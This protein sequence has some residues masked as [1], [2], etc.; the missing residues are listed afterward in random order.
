MIYHLYEHSF[1]TYCICFFIR[2]FPSFIDLLLH[3]QELDIDVQHRKKPGTMLLLHSLTLLLLFGYDVFAA[4][5][6][7][8]IQRQRRSFKVG[9]VRRDGYIPHGSTALRRAYHKYGIVPRDSGWDSLDFEPA[10]QIRSADASGSVSATSTGSEFVCPVKVGGQTLVLDFDTGSADMWIMNSQLPPEA[11]VGHMVFDTSR[12]P[13]FKLMEGA[14]FNISY[15]D[16]SFSYGPVGTDTVD[17]GGTVV[18]NQAFGL[19]TG[20]SDSFIHDTTSNGLVGLAFSSLSTVK[21]EKQ[22][23]FFENVAESLDEP[24]MT[25]LLKGGSGGEYE[26]GTIDTTK[27][28]GEMV[29]VSVD[30]SNGFWQFESAKFSIGDGNGDLQDIKTPTSIVDTGTSLMLVSPDVA[31]AYYAQVEGAV[32]SKG[33]GGFVYPC[34]SELPSLF[35]ALG[36]EG[37][38]RIPGSDMTFGQAGTNITTGQAL[39]FGG[40]QSN[41]GSNLQIYG[42]TFLRS[43]FVVFDMRGPSLRMA[44]PA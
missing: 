16:S 18:E 20:L 31:E 36:G 11:T 26:F 2:L 23:N 37:M 13:S 41:Q 28:Q 19:P 9:R 22:K 24:V 40:L 10:K 12:S 21:P 34:D 35:V 1:G 25:S 32:L 33:A 7:W 3:R 17:I 29:N 15:G 4:P 38:A 39:C 5:T 30:I 8:P 42:D 6:S 44:V 14:S 27:Y 43:L